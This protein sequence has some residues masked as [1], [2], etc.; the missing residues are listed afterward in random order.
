MYNVQIY[1]FYV[2]CVKYS[3]V[4]YLCKCIYIAKVLQFCLYATIMLKLCLTIF[5]LHNMIHQIIVINMIH[6]FSDI[7]SDIPTTGI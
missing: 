5:T 1:Q 7:L 6:L 3:V 2:E 4:P